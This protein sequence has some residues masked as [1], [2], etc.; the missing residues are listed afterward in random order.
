M[1]TEI[2]QLTCT[3]GHEAALEAAFADAR[4]LFDR[5]TG[6]RSATFRR[7][8][9]TPARYLLM[10]EWETLEDHTINFRQSPISPP[11]GRW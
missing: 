6:C 11:G 1:I 4:L 9:E 3:P 7:S 2:A 10:I 5:A 8:I